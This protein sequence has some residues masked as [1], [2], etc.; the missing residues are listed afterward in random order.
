MRSP[1]VRWS[2]G[3][4]PNEFVFIVFLHVLYMCAIILKPVVTQSK[5]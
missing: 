3:E 2:V 5:N 1:S 4:V